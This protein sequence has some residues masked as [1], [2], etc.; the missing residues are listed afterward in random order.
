MA[1]L[2]TN[3]LPRLLLNLTFSETFYVT[4]QLLRQFTTFEQH[5]TRMRIVLTFAVVAA[6][7][8]AGKPVFK[9]PREKEANQQSTRD[10]NIER[11]IVIEAKIGNVLS[12]KI[13]QHFIEIIS[14]LATKTKHTYI[15]IIKTTI[16]CWKIQYS[17]SSPQI[18][19]VL[20]LLTP[21]NA[22]ERKIFQYV[23][24]Q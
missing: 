2:L 1:K 11:L 18:G 13:R 3:P 15:E 9:L 7:P 19:N 20:L 10:T 4:S 21:K 22:F 12:L 6:I 23:I 16:C 14:R 5:N 24:L 17:R 8:C